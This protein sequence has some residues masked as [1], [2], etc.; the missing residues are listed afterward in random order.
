[1]AAFTKSHF[2]EETNVGAPG[3]GSH[4][5][6]RLGSRATFLSLVSIA[7]PGREKIVRQVGSRS[8]LALGLLGMAFA[9]DTRTC[10]SSYG[11]SLAL[12]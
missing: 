10:V 2:H 12:S 3:P 1:M 8:R 9:V 6:G 7:R 5:L 11:A 4:W